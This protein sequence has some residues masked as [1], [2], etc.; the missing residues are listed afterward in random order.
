MQKPVGADV[1]WQ[2]MRRQ[3]LAPL[4]Q[5]REGR[6]QRYDWD[7]DTLA[8]WHTVPVGGV[9]IVEGV[10]SIRD[11]LAKQ[12][13]VTIWVDCPRETRL[14]RGLDRD[15]EGARDMW[16]NNWMVAEDIY[17]VKHLPI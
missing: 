9:V 4:S 16:V 2:R 14:S 3:V 15:G 12:Y 8:E 13:D 6:Y 7:T 5:D 17:M 1:D 11:E 10:Y